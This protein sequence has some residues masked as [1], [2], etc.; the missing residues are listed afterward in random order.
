MSLRKKKPTEGNL[1]RKERTPEE[2]L[3]DV[4]DILKLLRRAKSGDSTVIPELRELLDLG[5]ELV[6]MYGDPA[7]MA[8]REL[9]GVMAGGDLVV[10]ETVP[11]KLEAMREEL[12]GPSPTPL[13][14]LLAERVVACWLALQHSEIIY[15]QNLGKVSVQQCEYYQRRLDRLHKRFL[16]AT[17]TLAQIHKLGPAVQVNIAEQQVNVAQ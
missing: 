2:D 10:K 3:S 7:R 1:A 17:R 6:S 15:A 14:R 12:A 16:A 9:V 5:P 13:K 11:R 4:E 8:E